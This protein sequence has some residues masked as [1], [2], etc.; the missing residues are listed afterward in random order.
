[1]RDATRLSP[2]LLALS[3]SSAAAEEGPS[4]DCAKAA[5]SAETLVCGDDALAALDRRLAGRF[6]ASVA[7]LQEIDSGSEDA[8]ARLRATQRGWI[9]GRDECWK[10]EDLRSCVEEAYLTREGELVARYMLEAPTTV[11]FWTCGG[12]PADE[13]VAYFYDTQ[14][15]SVRLERGDSIDTGSLVPTASGARY[16]A[17]FGKSFWIKGDQA[18]LVW[19]E[20][21]THA[22]TLRNTVE[23]S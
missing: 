5:G 20:G 16:E 6:A 17:S 22:C 19:P 13:V 2:L 4:F 3:V 14:R 9:K 11:T 1:M 10:A 15:P 7:V 8:L 23:P 21:T 12:N 18:R